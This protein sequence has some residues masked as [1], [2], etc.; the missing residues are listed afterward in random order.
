VAEH[1]G[2][3]PGNDMQMHTPFKTNINPPP[4]RPPGNGQFMDLGV[5]V[6]ALRF[7]VV[8][9]PPGW[10]AP[11]HHTDTIDFDTVLEGSVDLILDDGRHGLEAGDTA[12]VTGVDH[13]WEVGPSGATA[14]IVILGTPSPE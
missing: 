12:I 5:P 3:S 2:K 1:V 8:Q 9:W 14:S 7:M 13:G 6:G 11:I 4:P 10:Q